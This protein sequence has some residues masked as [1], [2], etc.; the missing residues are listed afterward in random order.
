[1]GNL[2]RLVK[3]SEMTQYFQ[4]QPL[5]WGS[6]KQ[7]WLHKNKRIEQATPLNWSKLK[8]QGPFDG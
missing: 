4:L 6:K 8:T 1:M 3:N 7:M 5:E 2:K